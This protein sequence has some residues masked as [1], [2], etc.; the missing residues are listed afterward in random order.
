[1]FNKKELDILNNIITYLK[2]HNNVYYTKELQ[3]IVDKIMKQREKD[4]ERKL[5]SIRKRRA[6]EKELKEESDK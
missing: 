3:K 1:M 5:K 4:N 6:I 2:I